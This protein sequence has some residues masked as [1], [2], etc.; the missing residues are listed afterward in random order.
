[1]NKI[2]GFARCY[3]RISSA[4]GVLKKGLIIAIQGFLQ[5]RRA[6]Q[7]SCSNYKVHYMWDYSNI[8]VK[9]RFLDQSGSSNLS[10]YLLS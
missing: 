5:N 6:T 7:L 2:I 3:K 8:S 9:M 1:M 10:Q 4:W